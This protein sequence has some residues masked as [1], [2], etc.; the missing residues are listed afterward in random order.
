MLVVPERF[1]RN[2][3]KV[4]SLMTPEESGIWLLERMRQQ[5]GFDGYVDK[6]ILDFGCGVRFSQAIL[7]S[8]FAI[9]RYV[10]VDIFRPMIE[11]LQNSVQD[12]RFTYHF[13]DAHHALYNPGGATLTPETTLPVVEQDFD[14]ACMFSVITHQHPE[15]SRSIFHILRRHVAV[16]GHL[17]FTFFADE[18]IESFE[19]RS[20]E[21][22]GG[23]CFYHPAFLK[24]LVQSCG[25]EVLG[26]APSPG[27]L[28]GDT[29]VCQRV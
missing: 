5:I 22:N 24:S 2:S 12:R 13:I 20:P 4:T 27:P 16:G 18:A 14:I 9:G 19:D 15:D 21:R 6:K 7:N 17:F 28:I 10:G 29:L 23:R 8:G 1:N 11:F 3:I 26:G 25:W